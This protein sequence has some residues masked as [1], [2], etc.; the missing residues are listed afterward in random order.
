MLGNIFTAEETNGCDRD[1]VL[2][3]NAKNN[4]NIICEERG[5]FNKNRNYKEMYTYNQ[6]ETFEMSGT[7]NEKR[8][9]EED[10][11]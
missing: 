4:I 7:Y 2:P 1:V 5:N 11:H 9:P 8:R 6:K 3:P 10:L